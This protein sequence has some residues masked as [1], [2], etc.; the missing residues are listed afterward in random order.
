[1]T[2]SEKRVWLI[3]TI[4]VLLVSTLPY[5]FGHLTAPP[6]REFTGV[7]LNVSDY[8]QYLSWFREF[9]TANLIENKMTPEPN[10]PVFFNLLWWVMGRLGWYTGLGFTVLH[11]FLR[12][13]AG[14]AFLGAVYAFC[15]LALPEPRVRRM[16][17][18]LAV[19]A[20][21]FG[22]VLVLMKYTVTKGELLYP[23]DVY[24]AEPNSFL[25]IMA[26]P[27]FILANALIVIVF[28]LAILGHSKQQWRYAVAAGVV[29]LI[30]SLQ[31]AYD[32]LILYGVLGT[33][34]FLITIRDRRIPWF[35]VKS[36]LIVGLISWWPGLYSVW[37]T[38]TS[39]IWKEVLAQFANAGVYTPDPFHLIILMG[40]P[41][42]LAVLTFDGLF[43]LNKDSDEF[44]FV[45]GWFLTGFL[46]L[47]VPTD[48]QVHMLNSWQI[49]V[50]ILAGRGLFSHIIPVILEYTGEAKPQWNPQWVVRSLTVGVILI[51]SLTNLYLFAWRFVDLARHDYPYYLYHD[52]VAALKW[53]DKNTEPEDIVLSSLTVGQYIPFLSG[54]TAFLGHW[55]STVDFYGKRDRV[56]RFFE[57]ATPEDE[58]AK[59]LHTFGVD[60]V[61][62]G[63]AER[64]L[65]G[66][67]PTSSP[68]MALAFSAP[69]VDVYRVR[70]DKL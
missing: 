51:A 30:L 1:M 33:F 54:N 60:Y 27:H 41:L 48:F 45:K 55:A 36:N 19:F 47:Y 11:Q 21:G 64:A 17:F 7:L 35:L 10:D 39:P 63:P 62:Q 31:H 29:G 2:Y 70:H 22:W 49:P 40:L 50:C 69:Q 37:L 3:V 8:G 34:T 6:N 56:S 32:L 9:Q 68:W 44:L 12:L 14:I 57:A 52:E 25:C 46:L 28:V 16:A 53:L 20:A 61:F 66:Y 4:S 26:F 13:F 24:I 5:L 38:R 58:R 67:D 18:L 15:M 23:L 43:P 42:L 65:G 59:T